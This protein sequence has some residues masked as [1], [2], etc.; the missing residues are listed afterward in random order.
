[1]AD[2]V[3]ICKDNINTALE[4]INT[5]TSNISE[6]EDIVEILVER[7]QMINSEF[8]VYVKSM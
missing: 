5:V 2:T 3:K 7:K 6:Q 1:M 8:E 4:Q